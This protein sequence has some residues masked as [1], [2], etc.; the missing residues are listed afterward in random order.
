VGNAHQPFTRL[1]DAVAAA[2][3]ELPQPVIVQHGHTPF[4][5]LECEQV[6]FM[7]MMQFEQEMK[8]AEVVVL[9]AGAGSVIHALQVGKV[10]VIVPRRVEFGE[11]VDN[12]QV[13]WGRA[14]ASEGRVVLVEDVQDIVAAV[15]EALERQARQR[16]EAKRQYIP[17]LIGM[18]REILAA[19]ELRAK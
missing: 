7:E 15:R 16:Q 12:H 4:H 13:S 10:P 3:R 19:C 5:G 17:P 2:A 9:H 11:H 18:V 8:A 1:L 6:A 14:L